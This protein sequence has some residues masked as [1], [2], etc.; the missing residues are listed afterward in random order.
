MTDRQPSRNPDLDQ[1]P[2]HEPQP[3]SEPE[4]PPERGLIREFWALLLIY[5]TL[6]ILPLL[7]GIACES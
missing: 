7:T 5:G 2:P 4:I 6:V 1:E 3:G